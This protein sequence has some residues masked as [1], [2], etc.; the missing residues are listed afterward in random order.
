MKIC[1]NKLIK[2]TLIC[3]LGWLATGCNEDINNNDS[4]SNNGASG[5]GVMSVAMALEQVDQ[6]IGELDH[7]T[8][9][10]GTD[11]DGD[12]V[13]DDVEDYIASLSDSRAQQNALR[14]TSA[15]ISAAIAVGNN[16]NASDA[17]LRAVTQQLSRAI[18]CL[19]SRYD[20]NAAAKEHSD[21]IRKITANTPERFNA[22]MQYNAAIDGFAIK[23]PRGDT[24]DD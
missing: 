2:V 14:Q 19:W 3:I 1:K 20:S 17:Q 10:A 11:T 23:L 7:S 15:A 9:V 24:C 4:P 5:S 21:L 8:S 22:Y 13:R 18:K 12:G 6:E 16:N